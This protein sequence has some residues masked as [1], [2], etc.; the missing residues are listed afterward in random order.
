MKTYRLSSAGRRTAVILLIGA[1]IIWVFA[2]WNFRNTIATSSDPNAG[3]LDALRANLD[4]GLS[5]GQVIPALL[6]LVL[7]IAT[8]LVVWNILEEWGASYTPTDDGL[9]FTSL[10]ITLTYPWNGIIGIRRLDDDTDEPLD[11]VLLDADHTTQIKNPLLRWLHG[12]AYG[13]RRLPLYAG[14]ED[15]DAL[16]EEIRLRSGLHDIEPTASQQ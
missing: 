1:L 13:R 10:G 6:M 2:L 9:R 3:L 11:E 8:P 16:L 12:Q 5:I 7:I 4:R 15:R 14:L